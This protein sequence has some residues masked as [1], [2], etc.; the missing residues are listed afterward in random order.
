MNIIEKNRYNKKEERRCIQA[1]H[2][3]P[4]LCQQE[5]KE[6][7]DNEILSLE[8]TS[9]ELVYKHKYNK[10]KHNKLIQRKENDKIHTPF[11]YLSYVFSC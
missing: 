1:F 2:A 11:Q 5:S 10:Y 8:T 3:S 7:S 4:I 9:L 6:S